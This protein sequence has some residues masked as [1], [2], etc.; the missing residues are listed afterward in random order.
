MLAAV[1]KSGGLAAVLPI[2]T[3][4]RRLLLEYN[5]AGGNP[6]IAPKLAEEVMNLGEP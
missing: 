1:D 3:D 2:L 6:L 4:P 5:R